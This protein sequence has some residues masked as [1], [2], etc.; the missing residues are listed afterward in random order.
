MPGAKRSREAETVPSVSTS[1][2]PAALEYL[3]LDLDELIEQIAVKSL[4]HPDAPDDQSLFSVAMRAA[5]WLVDRRLELG[6]SGSSSMAGDPV[7]RVDDAWSRAMIEA[8]G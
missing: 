1:G 2:R 6:A 3:L 7:A 4:Q 5:R 8:Q